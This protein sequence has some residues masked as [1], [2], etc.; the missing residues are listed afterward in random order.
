MINSYFFYY[1]SPVSEIAHPQWQATKRLILLQTRVE[2][3]LNLFSF[4]I[5]Y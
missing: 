2:I 1:N 4:Q 5:Q 3:F